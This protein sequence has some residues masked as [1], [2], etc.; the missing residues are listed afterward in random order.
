MEFMVRF[1]RT[2]GLPIGFHSIP[3]NRRGTQIQSIEKL[4]SYQSL[5]CVRQKYSDAVVMWD[6]AQLGTPVIVVG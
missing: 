1:A 6:F 2:P 5:G 4:G 3:V